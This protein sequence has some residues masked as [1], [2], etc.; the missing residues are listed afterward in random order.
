MIRNQVLLLKS[1]EKDATQE[2]FEAE[3]PSDEVRYA[4]RSFTF[5]TDENPPRHVTKTVIV[6]WVP[7]SLPAKQKFPAASAF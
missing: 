2:D 1:G 7:D 5:D 3:F 4:V 6:K